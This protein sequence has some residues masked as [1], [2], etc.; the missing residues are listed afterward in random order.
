ML[1]YDRGPVEAS[2]VRLLSTLA[3]L[4]DAGARRGPG[5]PVLGP[6]IG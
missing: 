2:H 4:T 6:W 5:F 3:G 1:L